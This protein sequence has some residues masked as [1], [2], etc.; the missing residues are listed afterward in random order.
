[1]HRVNGLFLVF[2][3]SLLLSSCDL[4][5]SLDNHFEQVGCADFD[6][7]NYYSSSASLYCGDHTTVFEI[8]Y[9]DYFARS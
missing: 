5:N 9:F 3:D 2:I 1:M 4:S 8:S 6:E 7:C